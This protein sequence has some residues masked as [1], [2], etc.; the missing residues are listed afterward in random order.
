MNMWDTVRFMYFAKIKEIA[1]DSTSLIHF[2][3]SCTCTK[4]MFSLHV[5]RN[6]TFYM[7]PFFMI[8]EVKSSH[9]FLALT[10]KVAVD[11]IRHK[12]NW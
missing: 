6:K 7:D 1:I 2:Q 10:H 9:R 4:F 8:D 11:E 5:P 3:E 12:I